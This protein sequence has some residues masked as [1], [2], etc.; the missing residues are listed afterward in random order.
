MINF[1]PGIYKGGSEI[2]FRAQDESMPDLHYQQITDN[3][4]VSGKTGWRSMN[5]EG[6]KRYQSVLEHFQISYFSDK[7]TKRR[8]RIASK[9]VAE[10]K[11]RGGRIL[12]KDPDGKV[13]EISQ[14]HAE[15][16]TYKAL[17]K[18]GAPDKKCDGE[19]AVDTKATDS[20]EDQP[21]LP[22]PLKESCDETTADGAGSGRKDC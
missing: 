1:S 14:V 4:V 9:V 12:Q 8:K 21:N 11:R 13:H 6:N 20:N 10:I 15:I 2:T 16:F 17:Q 18:L 5:L 7:K 3:D 19:A 22:T